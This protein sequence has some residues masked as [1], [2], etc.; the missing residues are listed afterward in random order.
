MVPQAAVS[1]TV[2]LTSLP[3]AGPNDAAAPPGSTITI[4]GRFALDYPPALLRPDRSARGIALGSK[5]FEDYNGGHYPFRIEIVTF[6]R[7]VVDEVR[8]SVPTLFLTSDESSFKEVPG[9]AVRK[10]TRGGLRG[11]EVTMGVEGIGQVESFFPI[12]PKQTLHVICHYCCGLI[13]S[14]AIT[15]ESQLAT[16]DAIV[17][18]L[19]PL[20]P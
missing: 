8:R 1:A 19:R 15:M 4:A 6:D 18:S 9:F 20:P 17:Q 14:P 5:A 13:E 16:C 11:Y 10:T 2:A 3:S 7:S 12:A